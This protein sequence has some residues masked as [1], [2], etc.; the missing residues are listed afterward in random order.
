MMPSTSSPYPLLAPPT[1]S[2]RL[3][4]LR[5]FVGLRWSAP[6][7]QV[8]PFPRSP[9]SERSNCCLTTVV[10]QLGN[11]EASLGGV[12]VRLCCLILVAA[13]YRSGSIRMRLQGLPRVRVDAVVDSG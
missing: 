13:W 10:I 7:I 8:G 3:P 4:P 6:R 12:T 11:R 2:S 9:S 1:C 5:C